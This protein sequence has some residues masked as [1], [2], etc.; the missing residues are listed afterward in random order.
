MKKSPYTWSVKQFKRM[1]DGK[2]I[3]FDYPIQRKSGQWNHYKKSLLI[4]SMIEDYPV[5][6]LYSITEKHLIDGKEVNVHFILDGKQRLNSLFEFLN[7]DYALHE[8]IEDVEVEDEKFE[9]QGKKFEELDEVVQ[10]H[11]LSYSMLIYEIKDATDDQIEDLF[12]RFN[13]GTPLTKQQQGRAKT[14]K[15]WAQKLKELTNHSC[16]QEKAYFTKAQLIAEM[17]EVVVLQ[18]MMILDENYHLRTLSS[19]EIMNYQLTL[20][21]DAENKLDLV[22]RIKEIMNYLDES[23]IKKDSILTKKI[24]LPIL[25]VMADKAMNTHNVHSLEFGD[26]MMEFKKS[27]KD[28]SDIKTDYNNYC[29]QRSTSREKVYGR[30][31]TM[32]EHFNKYFDFTKADIK[33]D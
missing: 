28:M 27:L 32:E 1:Y 7:G 24:N 3:S 33:K 16:M 2:K 19:N 5:P 30:I 13:N 12:F 11:I 25:F 10:D 4:H 23:I 17:D 15:V 29:G 20:K 9:V 14:G 22:Q 18:A 8:A 26:W 21:K 6:A 31:R